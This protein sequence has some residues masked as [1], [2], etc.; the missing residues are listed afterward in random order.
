M[1]AEANTVPSGHIIVAATIAL[2][3]FSLKMIKSANAVDK[4]VLAQGVPGSKLI[5]SL[6]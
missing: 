2:L 1:D 4:R 5:F 6:D 3:S